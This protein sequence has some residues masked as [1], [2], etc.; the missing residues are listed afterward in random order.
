MNK[1]ME[2]YLAERINKLQ[3]HVTVEMNLTVGGWI[4][5]SKDTQNLNP[6]TCERYLMR[7]KRV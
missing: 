5:A 2:Y 6:G 3:I 1:L 7:Q 4:M